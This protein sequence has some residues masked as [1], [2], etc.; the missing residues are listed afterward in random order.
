MDTPISVNPEQEPV[1][2]KAPASKKKWY[3]GIVVVLVLVVV[4]WAVV[5]SLAFISGDLKG[6][7]RNMRADADEKK[8]EEVNALTVY[9][10]WTSASESAAFGALLGVFTGEYPDVAVVAAP[11]TGGAG[12]K[13]LQVIQA[14]VKAGEAPDAFQMHAAYEALPFYKNGLLDEIDSIWESEQLEKVMPSLVQEMNKF[15]GHYYSVPVDIHRSNLVWFN[16]SVLRKNG[17]DPEVIVSWEK[18]F[19]AADKLKAGGMM[20]PIQMGESWTVAHVFESVMASQGIEFYQDWINGKV[21]EADDERLVA[22]L[23]ILKRYLSYVNKDSVGLAWDEAI[24]RVISGESAFS[25][26]GD[27]ADGEFQLAG[28]EYGMDYGALAAPGTRGMYGLVMDTFQ[29]PKGISHLVNSERWLQVVASKEGQDAFNPVKGSISP[30]SDADVSKYG[31]YQQNAMG[32]FQVAKNY[33]PSVVHGSGAPSSYKLAVN[34][35]MSGFVVDQ[36]TGKA[37]ESLVGKTLEFLDE[38]EKLWSL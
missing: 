17:V 3:V 14:L 18:L 7:N 29:H 16:Q 2:E 12:F 20:Y 22:A 4:G 5:N 33:F 10:W 31:K 38:Y 1:Q 30:R 35:I 27:W 32:D 9:H 36:D 23:G 37:A 19:E 21:T 13:M 34:E 6:K 25:L 28:M 24:K 15:E 8:S 11:V 26:M